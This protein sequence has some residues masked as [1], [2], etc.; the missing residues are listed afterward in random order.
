[1]VR[2]ERKVTM[3][4][5]VSI[6][7]PWKRRVVLCLSIIPAVG[8]WTFLHLI[9]ETILDIGAGVQTFKGLWKGE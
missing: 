8:M 4:T 9:E 2:Q 1:M 7:T 3:K 5:I 6:K